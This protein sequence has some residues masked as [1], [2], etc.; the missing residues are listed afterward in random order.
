[1]T[2]TLIQSVTVGSGG[3]SRIEFTSIPATFTDLYLVVSPKL[4]FS[5][6]TASM[7]IFLNAESADTSYFYLRGTGSGVTSA[8][9]SGR[10]DFYIG[11]AP[12][13][14]STASTFGSFAVYIPNYLG[15]QQKSMTSEGV[16]ET[17]GTTAYQF[18]SA[19]LCSK[20][21]AITSITVRGFE[22]TSGDLVQYSS[23]SL[24]GILK[25]SDG[26]VTVS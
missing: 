11:E 24:Y 7:G 23:A 22:Q 10:L 4:S 12:A 1:M 2:M 15:S 5:A 6:L 17:N 25:G 13:N 14:N 9:D 19:G 20:T 18:V 8:N 16:H 3:A 21:A 26:I